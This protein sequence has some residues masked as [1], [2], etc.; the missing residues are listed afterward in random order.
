MNAKFNVKGIGPNGFFTVSQFGPDGTDDA[1]VCADV[2]VITHK[3][4]VRRVE[5]CVID[6]KFTPMRPA[7]CT[8][9]QIGICFG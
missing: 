4:F 6:F 7:V 5:R 8:L 1:T 9:C 3:N 2:V